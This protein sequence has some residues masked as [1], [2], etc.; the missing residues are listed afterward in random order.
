MEQL[1]SP[2]AHARPAVGSTYGNLTD[3]AYWSRVYRDRPARDAW[4]P[5]YYEER[6]INYWLCEMLRRC[7]AETALEVG[8][9]DSVWLPYLAKQT[10][11]RFVAGLDYSPDGCQRL[12]AQLARLSVR[13]A[14]HCVDLFDADPQRIGRFDFVYSLGLVEHF[15]NLDE[16]LLQLGRFVAPGGMLVCEVPNLCS[17]HGL[18]MR[19]WQPDLMAKH[20]CLSRRALVRAFRRLGFEQVEGW[21][22]GA[23]SLAV[24]AW[25]VDPRW[26][27]L[28][29]KIVPRLRRFQERVLDPLLR[30]WNV[31][32]GLPG[33]APYI[34]VCGSVPRN[35][36]RDG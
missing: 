23:F 5:R 15:P 18:A 14:V 8:A 20:V 31:R 19:I 27:M 32:R 12:E 11:L 36:T 34:F 17:I 26:P 4:A 2:S 21:Y 30:W 1:D 6:L 24:V 25:E 10:G 29:R 35:S 7:R 22:A 13:G 33:M 3:V 28:A 9:G 16:V